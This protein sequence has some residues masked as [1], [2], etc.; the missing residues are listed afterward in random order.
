MA[1]KSMT[2]HCLSNFFSSTFGLMVFLKYL[3]GRKFKINLNYYRSI[4]AMI[5]MDEQQLRNG[6][7]PGLMYIS[8]FDISAWTLFYF[9][10]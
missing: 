9:N 5:V 4:R 7:S 10:Q 6:T 8:N 3:Q 2:F 1:M